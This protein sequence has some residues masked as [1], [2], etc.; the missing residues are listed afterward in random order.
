[1]E[2]QRFVADAALVP[3]Q[4]EVSRLP[5]EGGRSKEVPLFHHIIPNYAPDLLAQDVPQDSGCIL[6][7]QHILAI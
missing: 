7:I 1:M 5:P 4:H 3:V 2:L 6:T